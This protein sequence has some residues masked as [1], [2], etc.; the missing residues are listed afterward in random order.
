MNV[1]VRREQIRRWM[2]A[3][4]VAVA[5]LFCAQTSLVLFDRVEHA[6]E[7]QHEPRP[8]AGTP[9]A[10]D[11]H[12]S[13]A[14]HNGDPDHGLSHDHMNDVATTVLVPS[15]PVIASVDFRQITKQM[16]ASQSAP[17]GGF[18]TPD[19]PPKA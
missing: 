8:M 7:I 12:N 13:E 17:T 9:I 16:P 11:D 18:A 10:I 4:C 15:T 2:G 3:F 5:C 19:R 6:L 14:D 1:I